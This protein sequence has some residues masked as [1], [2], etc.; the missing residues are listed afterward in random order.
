MLNYAFRS[1]TEY[2]QSMVFNEMSQLNIIGVFQ[3]FLDQNTV[4]RVSELSFFKKKAK[5][6]L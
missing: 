4:I 2:R 5:K 1:P 3:R 6:L